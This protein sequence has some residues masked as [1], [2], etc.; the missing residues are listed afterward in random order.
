MPKVTKILG[1]NKALA[2]ESLGFV[3]KKGCACILTQPRAKTV[4]L[5]CQSVFF[6]YFFDH[7][8]SIGSMDPEEDPKYFRLLVS[9]LYFKK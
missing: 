3:H 8:D 1:N 7:L 2:W 5:S 9:S 6:I 4:K